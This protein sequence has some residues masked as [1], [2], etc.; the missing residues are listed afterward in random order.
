MYRKSESRPIGWSARRYRY[1]TSAAAK[2]STNPIATA[3]AASLMCWSSAGWSVSDQWSAT[4]PVQKKWFSVSHVDPAPKF[5]IT[6][7]FAR[8]ANVITA[9]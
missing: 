6:G 3:I 7:P 8:R 5:G 2:A 1:A 4:H 9:R